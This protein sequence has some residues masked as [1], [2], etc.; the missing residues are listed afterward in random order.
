MKHC[1]LILAAA[2]MLFTAFVS[3]QLK[4]SDLIDAVKANNLEGVRAYLDAALAQKNANKMQIKYTILT[5]AELKKP[6]FWISAENLRQKS[7]RSRKST[8]IS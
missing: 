6:P 5:M 1:K 2:A 4:Q 3:A 8:R 7:A